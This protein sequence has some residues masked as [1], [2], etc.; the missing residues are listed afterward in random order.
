MAARVWVY[1]T[2]VCVLLFIAVVSQSVSAIF[3]ISGARVRHIGFWIFI[4]V[5]HIWFGLIVHPFFLFLFYFG[6]LSNLKW[7]TIKK[8]WNLTRFS[9]TWF[10]TFPIARRRARKR[11]SNRSGRNTTVAS[12]YRNR[13]GESRQLGFSPESILCAR[14]SRILHRCTLIIIIAVTYIFLVYSSLSCKH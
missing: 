8:R 10:G 5:T 2:R 4:K 3:A 1:R 11:Y 12:C 14:I 6:N 9:T 7:V 13:R